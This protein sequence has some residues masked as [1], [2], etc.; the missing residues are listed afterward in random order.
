MTVKIEQ[1]LNLKNADLIG[2]PVR[3]TVSPKLLDENE[4]EIKVRKDGATSTVKVDIC[5]ETVKEML[6]TL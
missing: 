6:K 3:I 1:A 5:A 2:Y 4:V